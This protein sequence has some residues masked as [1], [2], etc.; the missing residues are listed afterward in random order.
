MK[1]KQT[2]SI[3]W[4]ILIIIAI[5]L[6]SF[7]FDFNVQD[8]VEDEQTQS[9]FTYIWSNVSN[10]YQTYLADRVNYLWND[11]FLNTIWS[12]YIENKELI[13]AGKPSIFEQAAPSIIVPE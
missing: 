7:F 13:Q 11:I 6:A 4:I 9:N 8:V 12:N 10:L 1:N 5:A 3:K 2:G